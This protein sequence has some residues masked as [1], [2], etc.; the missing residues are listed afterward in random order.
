MKHSK[1]LF[2][3]SQLFLSVKECCRTIWPTRAPSG[4]W[5]MSSISIS[6]ISSPRT[7]L[8]ALLNLHAT[9]S[10]RNVDRPEWKRWNLAGEFVKVQ[11]GAR[12]SALLQLI[13]PPDWL[14]FRAL[15]TFSLCFVS[16]H[17]NIW[18]LQSHYCQL[19]SLDG[20][21]RLQH[22]HRLERSLDVRG[23]YENIEEVLRRWVPMR[24]FVVHSKPMEVCDVLQSKKLRALRLLIKNFSSIRCDNIRDCPTGEDERDCKFCNYD[25]FKCVSDKKCISDKWYCDGVDDCVDGSDEADCDIES[26]EDDE[27]TILYLEDKDYAQSSSEQDHNDADGDRIVS[28][29]DGIV[30]IFINPN[31]S[32]A[33]PP[34]PPT[35]T[36]VPRRFRSTMRKAAATT[37]KP[38]EGT[39]TMKHKNEIVKASTSHSSPC[40]EFELRCVDGLCITLD[41]ICDKVR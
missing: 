7:V 38:P 20:V 22:L 14:F 28:T 41:Q 12:H 13:I 32:S 19:R 18:K 29:G 31:A 10:S 35:T 8:S 27:R 40:P 24:R 15:Q 6:S 21:F 9:C 23:H 33:S 2:D 11:R 34:P 4:T 16:R 26:G 37:Q 30:P 5:R 3:F 25:E 36:K 39:T 17:R 1:W